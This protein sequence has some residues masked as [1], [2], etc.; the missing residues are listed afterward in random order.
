MRVVLSRVND[1]GGILDTPDMILV[2]FLSSDARAAGLFTKVIGHYAH[3][4]K[5]FLIVPVSLELIEDCLGFSPRGTIDA[6][7]KCVVGATPK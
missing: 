2:G 7:K 6:L 3:G 1:E 5:E 4:D